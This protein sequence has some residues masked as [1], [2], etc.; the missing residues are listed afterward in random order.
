MAT[1]TVTC[2]ECSKQIKAPAEVAGKKIRCKGCGHTFAARA[3]KDGPDRASAI[4]APTPGKPGPKPGA[5]KP[6]E[7]PD[8]PY[9]FVDDEDEGPAQYGVTDLDMTPRCPHCANEM[10]SEE[11]VVCLHCGYNTQTR[12]R[13]QSRKVRD[14]TGGEQFLWLLPG[15]LC[16]VLAFFLLT[17]AILNTVGYFN[18]DW[19]EFREKHGES[20]AKYGKQGAVCCVIWWWVL[21]LWGA[22]K[23]GR[24]AIKRLFINNTPPEV[25]EH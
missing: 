23:S 25:E 18:I 12:E 13:V 8:A 19:D 7:K 9:K 11:A 3:D 1:I 16:A 21:M 2:P 20:G 24:F 17:W 14:T 4:K 6:A 15:I 10:E 5:D 22:Y